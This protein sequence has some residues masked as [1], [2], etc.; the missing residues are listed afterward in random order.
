MQVAG[1]DCGTAQKNTK[2]IPRREIEG[3]NLVLRSDWGERRGESRLWWVVGVVMGQKGIRE[4]GIE[5][6][7]W[8][9]GMYVSESD[10]ASGW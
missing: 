2:P 6:G 1:N 3:G 7:G 5:F 4:Y 8:L 10:W 9:L